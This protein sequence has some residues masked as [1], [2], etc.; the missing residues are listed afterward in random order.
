MECFNRSNIEELDWK[1]IRKTFLSLNPELGKIID[2]LDPDPTFTFFK[3]S[4]PFGS[5]L[6]KNGILQLPNK[7]GTLV[8]FYDPQISEKIREKL[9][10][11]LGS[12]PVSMVLKNSAELFMQLEQRII[13]LYGIILPGKVFGL[14][15]VL[16]PETSGSPAFMWGMTAGARSLFML[17]KISKAGSHQKLRQKIGLQ[18]DVPQ[19]LLDHWHIFREIESRTV[20]EN[21]W[22]L[23]ILFFSKKW[24]EFQKDEKW[25][26]FNYWLT[27]NAWAGSEFYRNEF[28]WDMVFSTIQK[29]KNIRTE[30][31]FTNTIRHL[32]AIGIGALC[33]FAPAIND[34][35]GPIQKIQTIYH[36]I[37]NLSYA[38]IIMQPSL[39]SFS[40]PHQPVYYSLEYP[41]TFSAPLKNRNLANKIID[42]AQIHYLLE[43][44]RSEILH[45]KLNLEHTSYYE[46]IKKANYDFFHTDP[47]NNT[48]I[49]PTYQMAIEDPS[50]LKFSGDIKNV[51]FPK[52]SPFIRGCIRISSHSH[53]KDGR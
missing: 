17:P 6:L 36:D 23:E 1:A 11:N 5:E 24:F 45:G 52:N 48:Y 21:P 53:A 12:N 50:L 19:S 42:L 25:L 29:I 43:K 8:P 22:N 47:Q 31:Y 28:I 27:K 51:T 4:C 49:R 20:E 32:F 46:G 40:N 35:A 9:G 10:Y 2:D 14:W 7:N 37:Y 16:N 41:T 33:G 26:K 30:P 3:L 34:E 38:P 39:F 15:R 44:F 13:P 18:A